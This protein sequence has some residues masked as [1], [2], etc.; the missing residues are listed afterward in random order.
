M[1]VCPSHEKDP[2][3]LWEA[4]LDWQRNAWE[5]RCLARTEFWNRPTSNLPQTGPKSPG[6]FA[7]K[8]HEQEKALTDP[9]GAPVW[10]GESG[11]S[12][13]TALSTIV[14][15]TDNADAAVLRVVTHLNSQTKVSNPV[16]FGTTQIAT[17]RL[18]D[19][20]ALGPAQELYDLGFPAAGGQTPT[21]TIAWY[22]EPLAGDPNGEWLKLQALV[23]P[24]HSGGPVVTTTAPYK[25]IGW[26][27]R[28][29][30]RDELSQGLNH[31]RPIDSGKAVI[32]AALGHPSLPIGGFSDFDSLCV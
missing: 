7:A 31:I 11:A 23:M 4:A 20:K 28:N 13:A 8:P 9:S 21:P 30:L 6:Y 14:L 19:W 25:V 3:F 22:A 26:N 18:G 5:A 29:K 10:S 15:A 27:V 1:V 16:M 24:G 17:L 32:N 12:S 2:E